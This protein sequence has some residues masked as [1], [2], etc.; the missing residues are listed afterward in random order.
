MTN[1]NTHTNTA[2]S[3]GGMWLAVASLLMI[4]ALVF[5]GPIAPDLHDQMTR[6]ADASLR[7]SVVHWLAAAA[8]SLYA[9]SGLVVLTS[10]SRLVDGK[11]PMTAWAVLVVG[12]LWT[13]TTAVAEATVVT[14]TAVSGS[15]EMFEAWW[16]FAEG[17][18]NGFAFLA[19]AVAVIAGNEARSSEGVTPKWSAW[20]AMIAGGASFS[21]W[22]LGMWFGV[23]TGNLLWVVS[24]LL[25]NVWTLWFGVV[26]MNS[27]VK[28]R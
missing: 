8:L 21:G 9:M 1:T 26:L 17:K 23:G 4:A 27:R 12:A 15:K 28:I 13:M 11:W 24:S 16:A 6:I 2:V 10:Q 7:W 20:T 14:N 18:A 5:H 19:L 25:M 3:V 22:A